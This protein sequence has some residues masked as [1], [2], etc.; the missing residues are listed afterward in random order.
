MLRS[1]IENTIKNDDLV[2][3]STG[4]TDEFRNL[5]GHL[6][7]NYNVKL[8]NIKAPLVTCMQRIGNRDQENQIQLSKSDIELINNASVKRLFPFDYVIENTGLS[9]EEIIK[10]LQPI[11][12]D[13]TSE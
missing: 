4:L 7:N 13:D 5:L 3:E 2:F 12:A 11:I 10:L 8:I 1:V 6:K 9:S